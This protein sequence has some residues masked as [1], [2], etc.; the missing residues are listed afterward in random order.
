MEVRE[1]WIL[2]MVLVL[3]ESCLVYWYIALDVN[4][5]CE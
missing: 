5:C 2:E 1:G 3:I 4:N